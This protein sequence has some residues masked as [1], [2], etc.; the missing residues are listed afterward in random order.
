MTSSSKARSY[1]NDNNSK[2]SQISPDMLMWL[3]PVLVSC[4]SDLGGEDALLHISMGL[5]RVNNARL[6]CSATAA[7]ALA[8]VAAASSAAAVAAAPCAVTSLSFISRA[9]TSAAKLLSWHSRAALAPSRLA[10]R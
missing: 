3:S 10:A 4:Q 6:T 8:A 5:N 2:R 1:L 7:C 9:A